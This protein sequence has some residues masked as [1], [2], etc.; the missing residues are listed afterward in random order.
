MRR[1]ASIFLTV[2]PRRIHHKLGACWEDSYEWTAVYGGVHPHK[3]IA[4][5]ICGPSAKVYRE[6]MVALNS[7]VALS[8][9]NRLRPSLSRAVSRRA[10]RIACNAALATFRCAQ[11]D[12]RKGLALVSMVG[13]S[14]MPGWLA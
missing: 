8:Q 3:P 2:L 4:I 13:A 1:V 6:V 12:L 14:A 7:M 11:I 5:P 9:A 10:R